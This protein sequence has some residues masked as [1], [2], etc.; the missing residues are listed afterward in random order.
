MPWQRAARKENAEPPDTAAMRDAAVRLLAQR[1]HSQGELERK[2]R[3]R[4]GAL[5]DAAMLSEVLDELVA[6]GLQ[7]DQRFAEAKLRQRL[8]AGYGPLKLQADFAQAGVA[9]ALAGRVLEDAD[10]DWNALAKAASSR[11]FGQSI[12]EEAAKHRCAR[13]LRSR[14]FTDQHIRR[15][16]FD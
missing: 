2:L 13:F 7:S 3:K 5:L 6:A 9:R 10:P 11:K 15:V 4:F 14:G 1:E 8:D 12:S 16:L